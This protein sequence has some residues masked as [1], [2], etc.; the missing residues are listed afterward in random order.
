MAGDTA[1][2]LR[3]IGPLGPELVVVEA[4]EDLL[5]RAR[6]GEIRALAFAACCTSGGVMHGHTL[7]DGSLSVLVCGLRL[8]E[9][10]LLDCFEVPP[11]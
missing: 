7:G 5:Q 10:D 1:T 4:L 9:R 6:S 3:V 11:G 2:A 8:A